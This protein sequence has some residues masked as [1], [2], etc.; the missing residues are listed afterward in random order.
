MVNVTNDPSFFFQSDQFISRQK[1]LSQLKFNK[2]GDP[3][4]FQSK[5]LSAFRD[6]T[7]L[8]CGFSNGSINIIDLKT[9]SS[10]LAFN[11]QI[12]L[13]CL[14]YCRSLDFLICGGW[15]G[16]IRILVRSCKESSWSVKS[17]LAGH[18]GYVQ[19]LL[20]VESKNML[21]S[22]CFSGMLHL[23]DIS[24]LASN[25]FL[26]RSI[27]LHKRSIESIVKLP[28]ENLIATCSSDT[29]V[30]VFNLENFK[31]EFTLSGHL[32]NVSCLAYF[33]LSDRVEL[34]SASADKSIIEWD[35]ELRKQSTCISIG[36]W[37][38]SIDVYKEIIFAGC[39]NG[40]IIIYDRNRNEI[41]ST[42]SGHY[43][44]V[45]WV[46]FCSETAT[47]IST[48]LDGTVRK[49]SL[50]NNCNQKKTIVSPEEED[51]L[52]ELLDGVE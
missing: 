20:F 10:H 5:V 41:I 27:Q 16:I 51:E 39:E 48:S 26:I 8:Y 11:I 30:K 21:I 37:I 38:T 18:T 33:A 12:P 43:D 19:S 14:V 52:N 6:G 9:W 40:H 4:K 49:W 36:E 2:R 31:D 47:L 17:T 24:N 13:S 50:D 1:E 25:P 32:T 42:F 28:D 15:D 35:L 3:L 34:F 22:G 7:L 45:S 29:F 23:W 44:R 46:C